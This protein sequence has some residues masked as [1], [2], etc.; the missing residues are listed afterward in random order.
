[1]QKKKKRRS[2]LPAIIGTLVVLGAGAFLVVQLSSTDKAAK[3]PVSTTGA[4]GTGAV[5][6]VLNGTPISGLANQIAS[7][8]TTDGF[9]RGLV[10][11]APDQQRATTL[12][13]YLPGHR[14]DA[15]A[16]ASTLGVKAPVQPVDDN[17]LAIACPPAGN[18]T[19]EVVVTVGSDRTH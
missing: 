17:S 1:V 10:T 2:L 13:M 8:L 4:S 11:N 14:A 5:V 9:K 6:A 18:C 7:K 15:Q 3:P 19:A 16:V 12:V